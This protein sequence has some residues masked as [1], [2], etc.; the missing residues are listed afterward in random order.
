MRPRMNPSLSPPFHEL[1]EYT[2]QNLCRN[3]FEKQRG[4]ATCDV[5]GTRGQKQRGI[6]LLARRSDG[7]SIEVGQCKCGL[8][9]GIDHSSCFCTRPKYL[10]TTGISYSRAPAISLSGRKWPTR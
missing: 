3:V 10:K 6:D 7:E 1:D 5:Y 4:I 8:D 2:Y 9:H